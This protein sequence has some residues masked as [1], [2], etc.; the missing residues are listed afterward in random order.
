MPPADP[1]TGASGR[2]PLLPASRGS[3]PIVGRRRPATVD[4]PPAGDGRLRD[5]VA[6]PVGGYHALTGDPMVSAGRGMGLRLSLARANRGRAGAAHY[7]KAWDNSG[8][9]RSVDRAGQQP[10][11]SVRPGRPITSIVSRTEEVTWGLGPRWSVSQQSHGHQ[12]SPRVTDRSEEPQVAYLP[13]QA[14][15]VMQVRRFGLWSRCS[16]IMHQCGTAWKV[17][18]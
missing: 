12:R 2:G 11:A 8:E 14:A 4:V 15:G 10:F 7:R 1:L 9:R 13:A 3:A 16:S 5:E 6:A 17:R 18:H